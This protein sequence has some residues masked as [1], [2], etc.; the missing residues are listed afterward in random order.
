MAVGSSADIRRSSY[1]SYRRVSKHVH[2]V[3][4]QHLCRVV[5][6]DVRRLVP[7]HLCRVV[8]VDVRRLLSTEY[9][10]NQLFLV[11]HMRNAPSNAAPRLH[12]RLHADMHNV[13]DV[14][15]DGSGHDVQ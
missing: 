10:Y 7:Q 13:L 11:Q 5:S 2:S 15:N 12:D 3:V 9:V 14:R 6:L 1:D 4:P 8:S